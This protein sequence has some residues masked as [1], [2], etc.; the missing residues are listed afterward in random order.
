MHPAQPEM[1][2][3]QAV[4]LGAEFAEAV[5]IA[6]AYRSPVHE[7][8]AELERAASG[9]QE[10][11]LVYTENGIERDDVRD[12]RFADTHDADLIRLHESDRATAAKV[13]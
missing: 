6:V 7:L 12:G 5:D 1:V 4:Q 3:R 9:A 2:K 10:F 8:D 13:V 11:R